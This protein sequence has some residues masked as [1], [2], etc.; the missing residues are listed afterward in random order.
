MSEIIDVKDALERVQDDKD[1][2]LE[3]FD[4]F[5][6]DFPGKRNA[7]RQA[8][9]MGNVVTFQQIAHGLKGA[10]GNI[11][12]K[13][14]HENCTELDRLGKNSNLAGAKERLDLLDKQYGEFQAEALR[15]KKEFGK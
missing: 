12:A 7:F 2:L 9:E 13:Q 10:T 14:M 1:L 11:S 8:M 4:I 15:L 6:E 3:L 5:Q